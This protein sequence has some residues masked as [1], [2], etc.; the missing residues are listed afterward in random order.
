MIASPEIHNVK[1]KCH[2]M[3]DLNSLSYLIGTNNSI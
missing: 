1:A 3:N 2:K